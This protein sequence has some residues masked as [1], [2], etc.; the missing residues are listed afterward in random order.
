MH[1]LHI[2]LSFGI[3]LFLLMDPF[4]NVKSFA[5]VLRNAE[6]KRRPIILM[7][8]LFAAL[9]MIFIFYFLG[10]F[11]LR[12]FLFISRESIQLSGGLILLLMSIRM[13]FKKSPDWDHFKGEPVIVPLAIPYIAGPGT[14]AF[15]MIYSHKYLN[16]IQGLSAVI[17][18]WICTS[19]VIC[20]SLWIEKALKKQGV[21][22]LEKLMGFILTVIAAE[23]FLEAIAGFLHNIHYF[24]EWAS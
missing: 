12:N 15:V 21:E 18:A 7:R 14:L 13:I 8:E 1:K 22:A 16:V 2:F 19:F 10:K 20:N 23:L 9:G 6:L 5:T 11:F 4:G 3:A 24:V 17:L